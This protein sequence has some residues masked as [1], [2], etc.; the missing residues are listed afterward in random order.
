MCKCLEIYSPVAQGDACLNVK[1]NLNYSSYKKKGVTRQILVEIPNYF[2][3]IYFR[4]AF[5]VDLQTVDR[6]S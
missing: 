6:W 5:Y 1:L 2:M 3:K 4:V